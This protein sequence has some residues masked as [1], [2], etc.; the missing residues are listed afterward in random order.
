MGHNDNILTA[1]FVG[2]VQTLWLFSLSDWGVCFAS[3]KRASAAFE[4]SWRLLLQMTVSRSKASLWEGLLIQQALSFEKR[5]SPRSG[6]G[7]PRPS[8]DRQESGPAGPRDSP[9]FFPRQ[10]PLICP[11]GSMQMPEK[12]SAGLFL[13]A[14]LCLSFNVLPGPFSSRH[15]S[16]WLKRSM[17][18]GEPCGIS[19]K[20]TKEC[21]AWKRTQSHGNP[22]RCPCS[23]L[24]CLTELTSLPWP[25]IIHQLLQRNKRQSHC[26]FS[27][28]DYP[29]LW[30]QGILKFTLA[31][32]NAP[33]NS[34]KGQQSAPSPSRLASP[35]A[36]VSLPTWPFRAAVCSSSHWS[37]EGQAGP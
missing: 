8:Q 29:N 2:K 24:A 37:L 18:P 10:C 35:G 34:G 17:A 19:A 5:L 31:I 22:P 20:D 36:W 30:P 28:T 16:P 9:S 26:I 6:E 1:G 11:C 7:R 12:E 13:P 27:R 23:G 3:W 4:D 33:R 25:W 15:S 14:C 32:L 21:T